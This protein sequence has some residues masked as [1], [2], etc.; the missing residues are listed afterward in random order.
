M[1]QINKTSMACAL[2]AVVLGSL[3]ST[4]TLAE[5]NPFGVQSLESGYSQFAP[6]GKC[7]EDKAKKMKEGKCGEGKCG[8]DKAKK[9]KEGKCG[10]GK[11]GEDKAKKMKEGKCGEDKASMKA[12][13]NK[14]K[15]GKCGEGKCGEGTC[16]SM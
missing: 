12:D 15:E 5:A 1:K 2:G 10:E 16:G 14:A 7:G 3:A 6:E 9:M 13:A 8:E 4:S 11:C